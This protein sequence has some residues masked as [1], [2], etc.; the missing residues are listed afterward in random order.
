MEELYRYLLIRPAEAVDLQARAEDVVDVSSTDAFQVDLSKASSQSGRATVARKHIES[1]QFVKSEQSIPFGTA[2]AKVADQ[3]RS[4]PNSDAWDVKKV[5]STVAG[6]LSAHDKSLPAVTDPNS[7]KQWQALTSAPAW[8]EAEGRVR[9]SILAIR[10][11]NSDVR[12]ILPL[13]DILRAM[14]LVAAM[15]SD[16]KTVHPGAVLDA[17]LYLPKIR[18]TAPPPA[19]SPRDL[20]PPS[21]NPVPAAQQAVQLS[22][23]AEELLAVPV[24]QLQFNTVE[25][26]AVSRNAGTTRQTQQSTTRTAVISDAAYGRLSAATRS[27]LDGLNINRKTESLESVVG[28]LHGQL[29]QQA[30]TPY[31]GDGGMI[32]G[33]V[34]P[35]SQFTVNLESIGIPEGL[36]ALVPTTTGHVAPAGIGDLLIVKQQLKRYE[37]GDIAH[38]ENILQG[39][40]K[41]REHRRRRVVETV[42]VKETETEVSEERETQSTSRFE[43]RDEVQKQV[44]EEFAATAGVK[45]S[46]S[47]GPMVQIEANGQF[48][49][50]NAKT[51]SQTHATQ[52]SKELVEKASTKYREKVREQITQRLLQ[53]VEELNRHSLDASS[54]KQHIIGVYQWVNKV[55]EAQLFNYGQ[56]VMYEFTLPEPAAYYIWSLKQKAAEVAAIPIPPPFNISATDVY[57]GNYRQLAAQF[58]AKDVAPPPEP[59]VTVAIHKSGGPNPDNSIFVGSDAAQIP[60]G[61]EYVTFA[62]AHYDFGYK[63]EDGHYTGQFSLSVADAFEKPGVV[64]IAFGGARITAWSFFVHLL[65]RRTATAYETWRQKT[66]DA[67]RQ[68]HLQQVAV[69]E[70]K[71]AQLASEE[72]VTIEG[73]NPYANREI[74]QTELKKSCICLLTGTPPLW[75]NGIYNSKS[76][77]LPNA[78]MAREQGAYVRF[79]EQAF[80]WEHMTYLF[81]PYFWAR[82]AKWRELLGI[83]DT[84]PLFENFL[85]AGYA[86]VQVPVR[87]NFEEV[88]EH[89]R[90]TGQIWAGGKLPDISDPDYLPLAIELKDQQDAIGTETPVGDPWDVIVPTQLVKLRADGSLPQ[91]KKGPDGAWVEA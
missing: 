85:A 57:E 62:Y 6:I 5:R 59:F 36:L 55:Y 23:A 14:K 66:W 71:K 2:L 72:G 74:A 17:T 89:F 76:G 35:N 1:A 88:V 52:M 80:E 25:K 86:R 32:N 75:L 9:G 13:V 19:L 87:K 77:P 73:R 49:Y 18:A 47:Y 82:A 60:A 39:E 3:F 10:E 29:Q 90:Q 53:E 11:S 16:L 50:K 78:L 84:D 69:Y 34:L 51:E 45:V 7:V 43:M 8:K 40:T 15:A 63:D 46:A 70:D 26:P 61:Y 44:Q 12:G 67:L 31:S 68:G 4:T 22:R 21:T 28:I 48:S 83:E 41:G 79:M 27:V 54:A 91:W 20:A 65:C 30:L 24:K 64:P 42:A 37:G 58:E 33:V 38:I 56:R 81:Y